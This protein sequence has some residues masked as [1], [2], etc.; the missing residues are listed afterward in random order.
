MAMKH[1]FDFLMHPWPVIAYQMLFLFNVGA[2]I[3]DLL[4]GQYLWGIV[5]A[6]FTA[7]WL[8]RGIETMED[9]AAG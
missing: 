5:S 4:A 8:W 6:G 9:P 3:V 2:L 1:F 7:Y